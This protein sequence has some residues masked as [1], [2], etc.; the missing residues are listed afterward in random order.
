MTGGG[1]GI[2]RAI[3]HRLAAEGAC[4]VVVDIDAE[5]A[6]TVAREVGGSDV[7]IGLACDVTDQSQVATAFRDAT[8]AFGGVDLVVNN[9]GLSISKSLF[10]TT[11]GLGS[12]ARCHG[13]APSWS[14]ARRRGSC[15]TRGWAGISSTSSA[16]TPS[17]PGRTT[18]RTGRKPIRH[19]SPPPCCRA[20]EFGIRV[21]GVN[22]DGWCGSGIFAKGWGADRARTYGVPEDKLGEFYAQ[23]TLLKKEVLPE[24]VA[25]A[26]FALVGGNLPDDRAPRPRRRR[27]GGRLPQVSATDPSPRSISARRADASSSVTSAWTLELDE[28]HRFANDAVE[29][30]EGLRWDALGQYHEILSGLRIAAR[31]GMAPVSIGVDTWGVDGLL[32]GDGALIGAPVHYRDAGHERGVEA[33][34][35]LI[36]HEALYARNGLQFLPFNTLSRSARGSASFTAA[37]TFLLMPD[38]FAYW[39]TGTMTAERTNASTTGLVDPIDRSG[40]GPHRRGGSPRGVVPAAMTPV[41]CGLRWRRRRACRVGRRDPRRFARH[42]LGRRRGACVGRAVRL[43]LERDLVAG[44]S[45]LDRPILSE[46]SRLANF[47]NEAVGSAT[48]AT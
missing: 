38:L 5:S 30:P 21:N 12:P 46:S 16:R 9:A 2:G 19:T 20:G 22:P 25:A 29:L 7:A 14:R 44:R 39:L 48:C 24:H 35:A 4:V 17:S 18:L 32:D 36:P 11:V 42:R 47:T 34:H 45:A 33:V 43:Y 10:E 37:R 41:R 40:H 13:A 26:V 8:L 6:E 27:G 28:V 1:S 15:A 23:R 31:S 3:A